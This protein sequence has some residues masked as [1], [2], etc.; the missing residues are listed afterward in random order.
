[1]PVGTIRFK[2]A[3]E[4]SEFE[5]I[6]RLNYRTFVEEIPQHAPDP[7]GV[8]VDRF[9][10]ENTY[11]VGM[12]QERV[13]AM[14]AVRS[15]R[16]FSLDEKLPDLDSHLPP[17][18]TIC[19]FRL[20]SIE[21]EFR[22]GVVFRSLMDATAELCR[23]R[24]YDMGI[25]SGTTRQ[26]K[27]YRH[28][29]FKPFGPLV[30]T[31]EA[32]FQPMYMTLEA[33]HETGAAI[34]DEGGSDEGPRRYFLPG[35]VAISD[36]V[37]EA[38]LR[39]PVSTR[40]GDFVR[41][42][43]R[44]RRLLCELTGAPRVQILM[45]SGTLANDAVA[46][47]LSVMGGVGLVLSNGEFGERLVDQASRAKLPFEA[48]RFGW[49]ETLDLAEVEKAL[50]REPRPSWL[51]SVHCESSTGIL[52]DLAALKETCARRSVLLCMDCVSSLGTVPVDLSGVFLATSVS[53]KALAS[54]P[55]LAMVFH[56]RDIP[57]SESLPRY[58]DLGYYAE[59][60]G[61]AF[62]L[63]SNLVHALLAAL[64]HFSGEAC[65][66]DLL[67]LAHWLRSRLAELNLPV[68]APEKDA[69]PAII[70]LPLPR[71]VNSEHVGLRLEEEGH[72]LSYRSGYLLSRNWLQICL[73]G[74]V[75]REDLEALLPRLAMLVHG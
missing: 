1:M 57:V 71:A 5:Q 62:T 27:L 29:G 53:G 9:H 61:I 74:D 36:I 10:D 15:R 32:P 47:Q 8:R 38:F 7:K 50:D 39:P 11:I 52:N 24:G 55:G 73:M 18:R 59:H 31:V 4:P 41:D 46:A 34:I 44:L 13:V 69:T 25:L 21:P 66:H 54:F 49:G 43:Q 75:G 19:E 70:T 35:P 65:Y 45:G 63:S 58:L 17:G 12:D 67:D 28:M 30:G 16:P 6:H 42:F 14:V 56:D 20:L 2:I 23:N 60:Q 22:N 64:E 40:S 48:I 26:T 68:L 33:F 72:L 3:T 37:R 51:W